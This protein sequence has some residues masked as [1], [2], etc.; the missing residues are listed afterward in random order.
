MFGGLFF[1]FWSSEKRG[2]K[3]ELSKCTLCN[4][5]E[6]ESA[7]AAAT[8]EGLNSKKSIPAHSTQ[9]PF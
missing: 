3:E 6:T 5:P 9:P 1:T 2:E 7:T 4:S 8:S